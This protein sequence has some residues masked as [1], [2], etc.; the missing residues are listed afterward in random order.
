M[1]NQ[2]NI[3]QLNENFMILYNAQYNKYDKDTLK[4]ILIKLTAHF[5][6]QIIK[7]EY[8]YGNTYYKDFLTIMDKMYNLSGYN[9][10]FILDLI[11]DIY[12]VA[13]IETKQ[14]ILIEYTKTLDCLLIVHN[15]NVEKFNYMGILPKR[16]M[17]S[18]KK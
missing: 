2:E 7:S 4:N 9:I 3:K 15:R 12:N 13:L 1:L 5:V 6:S 10:N 14:E 18:F 17:I 11:F 16:E 8:C